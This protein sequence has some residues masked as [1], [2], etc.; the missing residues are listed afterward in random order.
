MN[1]DPSARI[2]TTALIDRTWPRG[3][4][5]A[6]DV[7]IGEEA[8]ILT[9]DMTRGLF[10]DTR[11]GRGT[12][13]GPRAIVLPGVTIGAG[14]VVLAGA[15][16]NRDIPDGVTVIGNPARPIDETSA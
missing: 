3:V 7:I 9:H 15:L 6:A 1:I 11:I 2:A 12:V 14:C 4:H 16:V 13:I 10:C 8:V 5:I